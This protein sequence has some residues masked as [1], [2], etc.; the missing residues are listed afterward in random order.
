MARAAERSTRGTQRVEIQIMIS[1][2]MN[3]FKRGKIVE[4]GRGAITEANGASQI[5]EMGAQERGVGGGTCN[6]AVTRVCH[7]GRPR[8]VCTR[9]RMAG[10]G[11]AKELVWALEFSVWKQDDP[12]LQTIGPWLAIPKFLNSFAVCAVDEDET[13]CSRVK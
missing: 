3:N 9:W 11:G 10:G 4:Q 12:V 1:G 2:T 13:R 8:K 7:T 5:T 6:G